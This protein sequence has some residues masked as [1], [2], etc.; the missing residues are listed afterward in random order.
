M[1]SKGKY[2]EVL[3]NGLTLDHYYLLCNM[4]SGAAISS[5]KRVQGF[6]NLLTKKDYIKDDGLTEKALALLENCDIPTDKDCA[7]TAKEVMKVNMDDWIEKLHTKCGDK[8]QELTG[9]RQVRGKLNGRSYPFL[10][11]V[12]DLSKNIMKVITIYKVKDLDR[13][14]QTIMKH[15]E[16]CHSANHWF[17]SVYYYIFKEGKSM[18]VTDMQDMEDMNE[19]ER[20]QFLIIRNKDLFG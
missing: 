18:L 11:N 8:I 13:I 7:E 12:I 6:I 16:A 19:Q 10:P 1:I 15:I 20:E 3:E 14:E 4:R 5:N 17:P 2:D 9:K